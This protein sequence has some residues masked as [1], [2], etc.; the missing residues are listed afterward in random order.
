MYCTNCGAEIEDGSTVCPRCGENIQ[1]A[2]AVAQA[3]KNWIL[4]TVCNMFF[5]CFGAH[6]FYTGHIGIGVAQLLT[7][8]GLGFWSFVD[9]LLLCFNLYKDPNGNELEGYNM[10]AGII[11]FIFKMLPNLFITL[12]CLF[13]ITVFIIA[14]LASIAGSTSGAY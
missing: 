10:P 6:R 3:P 5:G 8:G 9:G 4:A 2:I 13:F 7:L 1:E 14:M 12:Y 11:I